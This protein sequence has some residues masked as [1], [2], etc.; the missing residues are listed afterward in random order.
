MV[1]GSQNKLNNIGSVPV[2]ISYQELRYVGLVV[3]DALT[4]SQHIDYYIH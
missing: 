2:T 4:W 1:I 3:D